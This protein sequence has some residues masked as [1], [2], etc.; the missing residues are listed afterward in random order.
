MFIRFTLP[1]STHVWYRADK[2]ISV[3][4]HPENLIQTLIFTAAEDSRGMQ[5][6]TCEEDQEDVCVAICAAMKSGAPQVVK[7]APKGSLLTQ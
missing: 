7:G 5:V 1:N 6:Y 4:K 3:Q 2:V